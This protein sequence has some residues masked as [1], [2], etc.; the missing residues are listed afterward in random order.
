MFDRRRRLKAEMPERRPRVGGRTAEGKPYARQ[1]ITAC[2]DHAGQ[3]VDVASYNDRHVQ[4]EPPYTEPYVRWCGRT[5]GVTPPPTRCG[6]PAPGPQL[7]RVG[8]ADLGRLRPPA[9]V[10]R[11]VS[12][13]EANGV[14]HPSR[15]WSVN[16]HREVNTSA[17]KNRQRLRQKLIDIAPRMVHNPG[18]SSFI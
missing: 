4:T 17:R 6:G 7:R 12:T 1:T 18:K 9:K 11:V 3:P 13:R 8:V 15:S 10:R 2:D 16:S 5:A 14:H